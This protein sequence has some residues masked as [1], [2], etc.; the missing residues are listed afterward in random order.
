MF[1]KEKMIVVAVSSIALLMLVGGASAVMT[2]DDLEAKKIERDAK[3]ADIQ[4]DR[5]DKKELIEA[6]KED[7]AIQRCEQIK[8][9]TRSRIEKFEGNNKYHQKNFNLIKQNIEEL[10]TLF[11]QEGLDTSILEGYLVILE[12]KLSKLYADHDAFIVALEASAGLSCDNIEN[13]IKGKFQLA[14]QE[15]TD[16]KADIIDIKNYYKNTIRPELISLK[17]QYFNIVGDEMENE[18]EGED[19]EMEEDGANPIE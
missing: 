18:E 11:G 9:K 17:K 7:R 16:I 19:E 15:G 12:T 10:V 13:E 1:K 5:E 3:K 8:E 2:A 14:K 6:K 4:A